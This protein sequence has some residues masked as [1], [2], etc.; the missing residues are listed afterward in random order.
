MRETW[1]WGEPRD[2][3]LP[4][5]DFQF[6]HPLICRAT[7]PY[8]SNSN[9][10]GGHYYLLAAPEH[11]IVR[12][13]AEGTL[14]RTKTH[15]CDSSGD[16]IN[17]QH[18]SG[19][20]IHFEGVHPIVRDRYVKKREAIG[21]ALRSDDGNPANAHFHLSFF[22]R[23]DY[24]AENP[25]SLFHQLY[26]RRN[27]GYD[28]IEATVNDVFPDAKLEDVVELL[29]NRKWRNLFNE[30]LYHQWNSLAT[31]GS[32]VPTDVSPLQHWP[33]FCD[34]VTALR[35]ERYNQIM[36]TKQRAGDLGIISLGSF[37]LVLAANSGAF[38]VL[39]LL[40]VA[41]A[42]KYGNNARWLEKDDLYNSLVALEHRLQQKALPP[43][44][45]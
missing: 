2:Y 45:E 28:A 32:Y 9:V 37:A 16:K 23:S 21:C 24:D 36:T 6:P 22:P 29:Q 41:A 18:P 7:H 13:P 35:T 30:R 44:Q 31:T 1:Q 15:L 38:L 3:D 42:I 5:S 17:L 43:S 25:N 20:N 33:S 34:R 12:A 11:T 8:R 27:V 26:R 14:T 10:F 19:D 40:G 39:S 4:V